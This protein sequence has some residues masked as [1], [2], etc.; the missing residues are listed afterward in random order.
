MSPEPAE[1]QI[2]KQILGDERGAHVFALG[3]MAGSLAQLSQQVQ[4]QAQA[5]E[6]LQQQQAPAEPD[7]AV[8]AVPASENPWTGPTEQEAAPS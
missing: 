4:E 7:D 3:T 2:L 5:I 1:L 6:R 8:P